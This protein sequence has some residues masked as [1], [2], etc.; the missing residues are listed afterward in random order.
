[1]KVVGILKWLATTTLIVGTAINSYGYYP[2]GPLI[3]SLG[4]ALWL[5]VSFI[6]KEWSLIITNSILTIMGLGGVIIK[7][8]FS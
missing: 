1:M 7:Y 4:G 3:L 6:W 8:Y 2:E 5:I